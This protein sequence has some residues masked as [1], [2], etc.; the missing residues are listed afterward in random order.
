M[1]VW[2]EP[3]GDAAPP[4]V[5]DHISDHS[6]AGHA[7]DNEMETM[8]NAS[9]AKDP[10]NGLVEEAC[11]TLR[12]YLD[13]EGLTLEAAALLPAFERAIRATIA[14]VAGG[15]PAD[16]P[17]DFAL[18]YL[19]GR[20]AREQT[21]AIQTARSQARAAI[22]RAEDHWR[23]A[24]EAERARAA[25]AVTPAPTPAPTASAPSQPAPTA[26]TTQATQATPATPDAS[27]LA[28]S[29]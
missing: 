8:T 17:P 2:R 24:I 21:I 4:T 6:E 10:L 11:A 13:A 28:Q 14:V 23:A 19:T 27:A 22:T 3:R 18:A 26:P 29:S 5:S 25:R 9:S 15:A 20:I 16:L 7:E 12:E 1:R